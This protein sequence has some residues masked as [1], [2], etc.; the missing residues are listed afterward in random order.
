MKRA[1]A[2]ILLILAGCGSQGLAVSDIWGRPS[3][4][5]APNA[6]FYLSIDNHGDQA[7][8]LVGADSP[9]CGATELHEMYA[10]E[11]GVMGMRPV[12]SI[13]VAAGGTV[14]LEP[15]GFHIMCI[16]RKEDFA[17]GDTVP[18]TLQFETAG[19]R[20][21]QVTVREN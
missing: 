12:E 3:A 21:Y 13:E 14:T 20:Q 9:A 5:G 11:D 2:L 15:G 10:Q 6:A 16:D 18:L 4:E 19:P 7:D 17:V 8:R 1:L